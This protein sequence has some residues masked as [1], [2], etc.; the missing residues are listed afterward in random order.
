MSHNPKKVPAI[1]IYDDEFLQLLEELNKKRERKAAERYIYLI[2]LMN[3]YGI[4]AHEGPHLYVQTINNKKPV[5]C[6]SNKST[7]LGES[8]DNLVLYGFHGVFC[9]YTPLIL[10][11]SNRL[12]FLRSGHCCSCELMLP[13][14]SSCAAIQLLKNQ[15]KIKHL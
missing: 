1:P 2:Q 13:L 3:V 7:E 14:L 5:F 4:R 9:A 15:Q 10:P 8:P 6:D 12:H 11:T